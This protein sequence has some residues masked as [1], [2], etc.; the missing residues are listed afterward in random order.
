MNFVRTERAHLRIEGS[1]VGRVDRRWLILVG[2]A[3]AVFAASFAAGRVTR[4]G[5]SAVS[6]G[7]RPAAEKLTA[8]S[9]AA[10]IPPALSAAAPIELPPVPHRKPQRRLGAPAASSSPG[11]SAQRVSPAPSNT[12][13]APSPTPVQTTAPTPVR[14]TTPAPPPAPARRPAPAPRH[15]PSRGASGG[16]SFESSG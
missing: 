4:Y 5:D 1:A 14:T 9:V 2:A 16:G 7:A 6:S 3:C 12:V 13:S 15:R 8:A 10:A 11:T